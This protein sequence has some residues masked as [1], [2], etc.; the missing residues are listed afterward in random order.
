[1]KNQLGLPR[2]AGQTLIEVLVALTAAVV[3]VAA[4]VSASLN[5]LNS[6]EFSRD[7][8]ISSQFTQEGLEIIRD[9]RNTSIAS[10]S[11][12]YLPDGT[13]CLAKSCTAL[14]NTVPSCWQQNPVCAQNVDKFV[15]T[16][17]VTHNATDCNATPTPIGNPIGAL[18]SNVKI[19][20]TTSWFD[21]RCTNSTKPFCHS[22]I[23]S[24]C[25]S[26]F[27]IVPTP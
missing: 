12:S 20:I 22:T 23:A 13:Y 7:Q 10:L 19:V 4:I 11:A 1:M 2:E 16:V 25:F 21:S 18:A 17:T 14:I 27:T 24:S 8:N 6:S 26:D 5:S 9:M 3:I 15:R